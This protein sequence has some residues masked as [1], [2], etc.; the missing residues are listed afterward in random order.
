MMEHKTD[1]LA[2]R[3][4]YII[5]QLNLGEKLTIKELAEYFNVTERIIQK[6]LNER[7]NQFLPIIK[8][9]GKYFIEDFLIGKLDYKDIQNFAILSGIQKLYPSLEDSFLSDVLNKKINDSCLVKGGSYE[10]LSNKRKEFD[11]LRLA[12]TIKH[13]INFIYND[14]AR[15]INPYKLVNNNDIWY[16]VGDEDGRL[17]TYSFTKISNLCKIE[18]E[19]NP[20]RDFLEIINKNQANWF[21]EQSIKV[22]LEI[23][24]NV[25]E[26]FLRREL[27]PNQTILKNTKDKLILQT[28]VSYDDEI[29]KVVKYWIP[30]IKI[31]EP[32]Y[33]QEKLEKELNLYLKS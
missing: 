15:V 19:F 17:K 4:L 6:D 8:R 2:V 26:Y 27:L 5:T 29:L 16:L 28:K 18:N 22:I 33:M 32:E 13:Q 23:D 9:D 20:N 11:I 31:I 30:H 1:K 14:K 21:S 10:D 7:L 3:F 25:S 12:I 24:T